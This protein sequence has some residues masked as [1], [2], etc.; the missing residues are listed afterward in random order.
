MQ[1]VA[2]AELE[3]Q[4]PRPAVRAGAA[5]VIARIAALEPYFV[6]RQRSAALGAVGPGQ[7]G[8]IA[9][10]VMLHAVHEQPDIPRGGVWLVA[11]QGF[12]QQFFLGRVG[13]Q[14]FSQ[15]QLAADFGRI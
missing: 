14:P 6:G 2:A 11:Q 10:V 4:V 9:V 7:F 12:A 5:G 3:P 13:R 8:H 15:R 1:A